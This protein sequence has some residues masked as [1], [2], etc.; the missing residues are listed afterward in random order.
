MHENLQ[1]ETTTQACVLEDGINV[2]LRKMERKDVN[3]IELAFFE[4]LWRR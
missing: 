2:D 1:F 3:L 4:L